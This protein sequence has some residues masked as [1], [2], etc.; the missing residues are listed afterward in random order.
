MT[1]DAD[2][3]MT[4]PESCRKAADKSTLLPFSW[5]QYQQPLEQSVRML[6]GIVGHQYVLN[7]LNILPVNTMVN[8]T[9][10]YFHKTHRL[11]L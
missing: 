7:V 2:Y 9:V 10:Y 5:S 11:K 1:N 3:T 8:S 4:R 6:E